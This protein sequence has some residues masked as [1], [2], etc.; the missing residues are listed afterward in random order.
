MNVKIVLNGQMLGTDMTPFPHGFEPSA[1]DVLEVDL[2]NA[3]QKKKR[4]KVK[5][6]LWDVSPGEQPTHLVLEVEEA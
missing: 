1:G 4:V 3:S 6:R 5:N 2:Q